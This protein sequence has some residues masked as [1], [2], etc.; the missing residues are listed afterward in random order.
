MDHHFIKRISSSFKLLA[1][2]ICLSFAVPVNA[3]LTITPGVSAATLVANLVGTGMTVTNITLNCPANAYGTFSNGNTTNINIANGI[4]LTTGSATNAPGPNNST[5]AGTCNG[6]TFSDPQLTSLDPLA[7]RDPCIL[8]FDIIPQCNTLTINFVFGSEEYPEFV[9]SGF[10]DAFGF[11]ITGPGPACQP[12]FY[13][14]TNVATLPNNTTIVSIDNVNQF[15][16]S[17][18]YVN[19]AGGPTIQYDGFTTVL[20]RNVAL[21]PCV[22]Y[23][24]KIAIADAGDCIYDSGV[25]LDFLS[26]S[27]ALTATTSTTPATCMACNGTA[28]VTPTGSAPFTYSWAPAGGNG[29][30]ASNLC[31]GTYTVTVDDALA[32]SPPITLTVTVPASVVPLATINT[33]TDVSCNGACDGSTNAIVTSGTG[34]YTYSWSPSGGNASV[35]SGLCPG[36]YTV[37]IADSGGCTGTASY[38]ITQPPVLTATAAGTNITCFGGSNGTATASPAGGTPGYIYSWQ[39]SGGNA[40]TATGLTAGNYTCLVTDANGCTITTSVALSEPPAVTASSVGTDISCFGGTNGTATV[41]PGGGVGSFTYNWLP[42]GGNAATAINLAAGTYSVTVTDGSGCTATSSITLTEPPALTLATSVVAAA[43]FNSCDGQMNVTPNGGTIPYSYSWST[44]CNTAGCINICA[45]AYTITV[46][47]ANGC[48]TTD[49]VTITEPTAISQTLSSTP[50]NCIAGDGTAST[51][52]NGGTGAYTYDWQPG[53][54]NA[55]VHSGLS[56]GQ[57]TITVTDANNCVSVDSVVVGNVTALSVTPGAVTNVTCNAACNGSL[58][59]TAN[60]GAAPFVYVWSPSGGNASTASNLC[61]GTY[62]CNVTDANGC[63]TS[64]SFTVTEPT[65]LTVITPVAP[66]V[67]CAGANI[68]LSA[69]ASGGIPGYTYSW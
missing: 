61:A 21:C 57:Y 53:N 9:N 52:A 59:V 68:N 26:C 42:S 1:S 64:V 51:I 37:N 65:A 55:A 13:N 5:S 3:Q 24:W 32:C 69:S 17:A 58:T 11:W 34:P 40:A 47:D 18:Y 27:T 6:V 22:T 19:N 45:G 2:F 14:N 44:G 31:A 56:S 23:H 41:I 43:C 62:T 10:N 67:I 60:G 33:Q 46:T 30:T 12:G 66:P 20:T 29:A 8:E 25:F 49:S 28:T 16:N 4:M 54:G 63:T 39:P 7:T 38:T 15:T 50:E 36:T 35:A 48:I